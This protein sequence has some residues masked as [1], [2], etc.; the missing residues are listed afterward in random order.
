MDIKQIAAECCLTHEAGDGL[1]AISVS[2]IEFAQKII[3]ARDA[4][5]MAEPFGYYWSTT[6]FDESGIITAE[7]VK[8]YPEWQLKEMQPLYIQPKEVK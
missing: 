3:D 8:D 6:T 2:L 7:E 1:H 5:W 4:E